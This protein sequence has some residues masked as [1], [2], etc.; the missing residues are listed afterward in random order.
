MR[1]ARQIL[2]HARLNEAAPAIATSAGVAS[3]GS[4]VRMVD[5]A[6]G[7]L[8]V[9]EL[10]PGTPVFLDI[11][12]PL[13]HTIIMLALALLGLPSASVS[14]AFSVERAGVLPGLLLT[15]RDG[16]SLGAIPV[17]QIDPRWV[18]YD[19]K[20]AIDHARLDRLP[21]FSGPDDIVRYVYSSGTTG[22]PKCVALTQ[23]VLEERTFHLLLGTVQNRGGAGLLM[24]PFSTVASVQA[25]F[26]AL[27]VGRLRC[28]PAG[29]AEALEM[30]R[31][32]H[33][34]VMALAV[35]QVRAVLAEL[36]GQAPPP[37]LK[38]V[39][40]AGSKVPLPLLNETRARLCSNVVAEYGSTEMGSITAATPA[41][42]A[43]EEGAVGYRRPWV[44]V[45]IVDDA[46]QPV[47][48]GQ[49][50][51]VR[52]RSSELAFYIND[53]GDRVET[54]EDGWFYPGDVGHIQEDGLVV[55]AGRTNEV[56]NRGGVI[57]A[58]EFVEE[59][60]RLDPA[61]KDVAVVGVSVGGLEEIWAAVVSEEPFDVQAM[62]ERAR[63]KLNEKT[64]NR[65][66]RVDAIPR[67]ES[68]K[69][70]RDVLHDQ[71]LV[72]LRTAKP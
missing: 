17:R 67:T 68:G 53:A 69:V 58:P 46:R 59:V 30:T 72:R 62:A 25:I 65:I 8:E 27:P 24:L 4:L 21:G 11:R 23:R 45:E 29:G 3:Y 60:L 34:S 14:S 57:V 42:L 2:F 47:P 44:E 18:A 48:A 15:D 43:S 49:D 20:L 70:T 16:V 5:A 55:I 64:P 7:A 32:F 40:V 9:L 36:G 33:V 1:L 10:P 22:F 37:D 71:L 35:L 31:V 56:I 38:M 13:H 52:A 54:I 51:I 66:L 39:L 50:G 26:L 6:V 63:L 19:T 61:V 12:N 28:L 41:I